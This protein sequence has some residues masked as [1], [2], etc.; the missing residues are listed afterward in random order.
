MACWRCVQV[1][2]RNRDT[3]LW[4]RELSLCTQRILHQRDPMRVCDTWPIAMNSHRP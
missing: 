1:G 2:A 3:L 4:I